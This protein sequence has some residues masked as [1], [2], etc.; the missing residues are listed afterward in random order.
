MDGLSGMAYAGVADWIQSSQQFFILLD[1]SSRVDLYEAYQRSS[2]IPRKFRS[3]PP[4]AQVSFT[5]WLKTVVIKTEK[6]IS[7]KV[8]L[9]IPGLPTNLQWELCDVKK[10]CQIAHI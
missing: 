10:T 1:D 7:L 8:L 6:V 2:K 3:K 5:E 9:L 4:P